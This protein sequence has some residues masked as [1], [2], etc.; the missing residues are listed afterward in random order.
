MPGLRHGFVKRRIFTLAL[1]GV[2]LV[3]MS[4]AELYLH[5]GYKPYPAQPA[6]PA[7]PARDASAPEEGLP[8]SGQIICVDP[9]HGGYDG[10]AR[11]RTSGI[12]EKGINLS[13]CQK[14]ASILEEEGAQVVLTRTA[15]Y[16]LCDEEVPAGMTKKRQDMER[17]IQIAKEEGAT[18]LISIHMNEYPSRSSSGPQVFYR[19]EA[20]SSRLMAGVMQHALISGLNPKRKRVAQT[21]DYFILQL[22][23]PSVLVECGFLSNPSEEKLLLDAAYQQKIAEAVAAGAAEYL[24][25]AARQN[26]TAPK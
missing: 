14:L 8:L 23:I 11:A 12:W 6:I 5:T 13:V 21:G 4:G 3:L 24:Q 10:G 15:D 26:E 22:D 20:E 16:A 19:K 1:C 18:M 2:F 9:G 7:I 25:L 17:R